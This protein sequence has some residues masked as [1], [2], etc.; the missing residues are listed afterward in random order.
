MKNPIPDRENNP[1]VS[2]FSL[3]SDPDKPISV[4]A[5]ATTIETKGFF[6]WDRFD[7]FIKVS[8]DDVGGESELLRIEVLDELA[9]NVHSDRALPPPQRSFLEEYEDNYDYLFYRVGWAK[10]VLP[11]FEEIYQSRNKERHGQ[12]ILPRSSIASLD[13]REPERKDDWFIC[14]KD[15]AVA[16]R[17]EHDISPNEEHEGKIWNYLYE[18]KVPGWTITI[19]KVGV[20]D[21]SG[22]S[23]DRENFKKRYQKYFKTDQ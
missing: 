18:N 6:G 21:L 4:A 12:A 23:M 14:I 20:L 13:I 5:I 17:K 19:K 3:L 10:E 2:I 8:P 22:K 16:F 9:S 11:D 1:F 15:A 7:R